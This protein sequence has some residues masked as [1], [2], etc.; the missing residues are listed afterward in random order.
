MYP[1]SGNHLFKV[2]LP[3][4]DINKCKID[5]IDCKIYWLQSIIGYK[6]LLATKYFGSKKKMKVEATEWCE[7]K[8]RNEIKPLL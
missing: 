8:S 4:Q 5:I 7:R 1:A 2:K 6:A 3:V